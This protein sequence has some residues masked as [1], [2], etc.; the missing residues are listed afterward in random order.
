MLLSHATKKYATSNEHFEENMLTAKKGTG[1]APLKVPF[2]AVVYPI[3]GH[4]DA[5]W[6]HFASG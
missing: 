1:T 4:V 2:S 5:K 6:I 3:N